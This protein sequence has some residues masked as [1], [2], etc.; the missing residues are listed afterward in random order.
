M[1]KSQSRVAGVA[2]FVAGWML[3][4]W[5]GR[6]ELFRDPGTFWHLVVGQQILRTGQVPRVDSFS[7]TFGG[8]P[9][10]SQWWLA[11]WAMAALYRVG[12]WDLLLVVTVTLIA[13]V[14]GAIGARLLA[15]GLRVLPAIVV[16]GLVVA[17]GS[18]QF[19]VRPLV[20]TTALLYA[21]MALLVEI[22]SG[23]VGVARLWWTVP[24]VALWANCHGGVL[25]G[26]GTAGLAVAG[27]MAAAW[28]GRPSPLDCRAKQLSAGAAVAASCAAVLAN[29]YGLDLVR[30]WFRILSLPLHD[31][32]QEH[33]RLSL[34]EPVG[35]MVAGLAAVYAATLLAVPRSRVRITWLL[36]LVWL[37]LACQRVRNA[38]LFAITAA[39]A[40][41]EMLPCS[42]L[43]QWLASRDL[44][45]T[46][47]PEPTRCSR[48]AARLALLGSLGAV[49]LLA[50]GAS[51]PFG[52]GEDRWARFSPSRWPVEL[53]GELARIQQIEPAGTPIFNDMA[54][55]GFLVY[56]APRL[57]VFIDDRCELYGGS[58]LAEY[59]EARRGAPARIDPWR[60]R[61]GF[62]YALVESNTPFDWYLVSHPDW[63]LIGRTRV[64]ALYGPPGE[65]DARAGITL[66]G[67][68]PARVAARAGIP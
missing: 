48:P 15:A 1:G 5:T 21:T 31:L 37:V 8:E 45:T 20:V 64:A 22:E 49:L 51:R 9:W 23:R 35:W 39:V 65:K 32:I 46:G 12:G 25:A 14:Y 54:F 68:S 4:F 13:A 16:L 3:L 10:E 61:H 26:L 33:A 42:R 58:F 66:P 24:L 7:F 43:S 63:A 34:R 44:L 47:G 60:K 52:P 11:E 30:G 38:Q 59:D 55:G 36:P 2:L 57:R 50:L 40:W 17:A 27:W 29:P 53:L 28:L 6:S 62:R 19:H 67:S 18:P 56:H 41:S